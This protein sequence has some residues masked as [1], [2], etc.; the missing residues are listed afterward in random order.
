MLGG[1]DLFLQGVLAPQGGLPDFLAGSPRALCVP[2]Q[3][4]PFAGAPQPVPAGCRRCGWQLPRG[5]G[6]AGLPAARP[7]SEPAAD[8]PRRAAAA[9]LLA[10]AVG[11]MAVSRTEALREGM[12]GRGWTLLHSYGDLL[13]QLGD[14]T[15]PNE[16]FTPTRIFPLASAAAAA[17][18]DAAA[19]PA[20]AGDGSSEGGEGGAGGATEQLGGLSLGEGE[21]AAAAGG[22]AGVGEAGADEAGAG[23]APDMDALLEAAVL[24]GLQALKNAD[25]PIQVGGCACTCLLAAAVAVAGLHVGRALVRGARVR[26]AAAVR[27]C[28]PAPSRTD[29]PPRSLGRW[30]AH[31]QAG[32]FYTKCMKPA[33]GNAILD[34]KAS[35]YKKLSKLLVSASWRG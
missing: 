1:A 27:A 19:P 34:I 16:G 6:I 28:C 5:Q 3:P 18:G 17:G 24:A 20:A 26:R 29:S 13:W 12:K 7:S 11:K 30:T 15:P 14:R 31:P 9:A 25:L 8:L 23:A 21:G 4:V 33:A 2:G 32:D 22:D 35:K 10:A